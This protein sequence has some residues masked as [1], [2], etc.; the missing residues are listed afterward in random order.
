MELSSA[1]EGTSATTSTRLTHGDR[2]RLLYLMTLTRASE[3]KALS[4]YRQGKVPGSFYDGRG[5]EATSVGT[6][7]ALGPADRALPLHR[8][9]GVHLCRGVG[10]A[11]YLGNCMG[12]ADGVTKGRDGNMHFG[13]K[14]FGTVG[15]VSMLPDMAQV[16]T[17]MGLAYKMRGE[18]RVAMS[19]FGDGST[20]NGQ[21]HEAMNLAGLKRLPVVFVMENNQWAYSTPNDLEF[22]VNPVER[23]EHYG[24]V[25]DSVDGNDVE[26]VFESAA[27]AVERARA[28]RG[29]TL[30]ECRTMRMHGHGA[31]DDM[32]YVPQSQVEEWAERDP[33]SNYRERLVADHSF[34]TDE[35][36]QIDIEVKRVV[37][38]AA[39]EALAMPM[40]DPATATD[41]V[42][43]E[44]WEPLRDGHAPWSLWSAPEE[45]GA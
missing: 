17:G 26:A 30:I 19:W 13:D 41:G 3:E 14:N 40:P 9:L 22:L 18:P 6:A 36:E 38:E 8:D 39:A 27:Q 15:M 25:G 28:G 5:Q 11:A 7:F 45:R 34:T 23:A 12:R 43:A 44:K 37:E 33:I 24:V 10:T 31:H 32:S 35:L 2:G 16:A 1:V 42:F 4:L 29:P 20:A 21:W